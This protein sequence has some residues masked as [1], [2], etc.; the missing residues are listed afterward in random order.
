LAK[1][2]SIKS[3]RRIIAGLIFL[4]AGGCAVLGQAGD[5]ETD[6]VL[7]ADAA[8]MKAYHAKDLAKSVAFCDEE[9]SILPPNAPI[10][11]AKGAIAKVIANDFANGDLT[12]HANKA[13]VARS[14]DLGYTSG[15]SELTVKDAS[16]KTI[17]DHGKFL[18]VWKKQEDGSWKVLFDMFSSD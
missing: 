14:G 7:A 6:A 11:T 15:T 17:V 2:F 8:W 9:A 12:W 1:E 3:H 13:G 10:A 5:K 4:V 16:G 18:T